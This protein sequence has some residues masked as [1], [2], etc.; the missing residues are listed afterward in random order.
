MGY[1][2]DESPMAESLLWLEFLGALPTQFVDRL[3]SHHSGS[4]LEDDSMEAEEDFA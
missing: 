2:V 4:F 3:D 1:R